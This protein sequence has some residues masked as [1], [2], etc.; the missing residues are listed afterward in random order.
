MRSLMAVTVLV[1][2]I[3]ASSWAEAAVTIPPGSIQMPTS[4]TFLYLKSD[5]GDFVGNGAEY[6]F[7]PADS[8]I[9]EPQ[10][11]PLEFRASVVQGTPP[12][13]FWSV[14]LA[15]PWGQPLAVGSYPLA[16]RTT[17][18]TGTAPGLDVG[19]DGRGC[20][21]L[22]GQFDVTELSYANGDL[23]RLDAT[24]EQHCEGAGPAL[25]GRIRI[26]NGIVIPGVTLPV[27]S[28]T[29]PTSGNFLYV[30]S[31]L[32]DYVGRGV[33]QLYVAP[34]ATISAP[35]PYGANYFQGGASGAASSASVE[36]VGPSGSG[37]ALGSYVRAWLVGT[38]PPGNPAIRIGI[39]GRTCTRLSTGKF[40]I[41]VLSYAATRELLVFQATFEQH[42]EDGDAGLFGRIRFEAP[43]PVTGVTLPVGS[44]GVPTSGTYLYLN[45]DPG[46]YVGGGIE[47]LYTSRDSSFSV[48]LPQ[49][50]DYFRGSLVQGSN[51]HWWYV[52]LA[53]PAG[54]PIAVG[55]YV[56]A[57]RADFRPAGSPGIDVYG[58]GRGCNATSGKFDVNE[59][60]FWSN[61]DVHTFQA[62]F[63]QL[64]GFGTGPLL[65]GRVRIETLPPLQMSVKLDDN[66]RV[67]NRS[68]VAT[69]GGTVL[70]SRSA[71]VDLS[72]V[73]TEA[74]NRGAVTGTYSTGVDCVSPSMKW[75]A[76]LGGSGSAFAAGTASELV[77]ATSC[78]TRCYSSSG[79][80]T[81][82]LSN[83][84]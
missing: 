73:L 22:T 30:N 53:A 31:Q 66:G 40:D 76:S 48:S 70:C 81:V 15:G 61:G 65:Y 29:V 72:G 9:I 37:L 26:E 34:S 1:A 21:T 63:Q 8:T 69:V 24:F 54:Q 56:R 6:L 35:L 80:V 84:S 74:T 62:T 51:V 33:E 47:Q 59:L 23:V 67:T 20:N 57:V 2:S 46:E 38:Q 19:G 18:R 50:G 41:D 55:S 75:S 58:D 68:G 43:P 42:C 36:F 78:D 11:G 77:T 32:G 71:H 27:G 3:V 12:T 13:H 44:V 25:Y 5:P 64:C 39:D 52:N 7:T 45:S 49:G 83:G 14:D 79:S 17:S 82:K 4:G 10:P 60:S 16:M 28:L